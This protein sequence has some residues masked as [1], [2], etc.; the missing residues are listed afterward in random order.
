MD[1]EELMDENAQGSETQDGNASAQEAFENVFRKGGTEEAAG[2]SV[3][4]TAEQVKDPETGE[5]DEADS[6]E[7][8]AE[9]W[10]SEAR[11]ARREAARYR[12]ELKKLREETGSAEERIQ[13]IQEEAQAAVEEA[14]QKAV[15]ATRMA[16]LSGKV[17]RPDRV[18]KL[19]DNPE[20]F[21]DEDGN[22]DEK[23]LQESFP[24][25]AI[26]PRGASVVDNRP[27]GKVGTSIDETIR[28]Q[29]RGG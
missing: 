6:Q 15:S 29:A 9:D 8:T 27:A 2:K 11:K 25:Y 28:R 19:M 14:E 7:L 3:Q 22:V 17:S 20:K 13:R 23:K 16:A 24:E 5:Q 10:A 12:T 26:R 1:G 21:F 4:G 18:L